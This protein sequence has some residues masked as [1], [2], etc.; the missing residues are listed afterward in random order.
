[1][2][3][4][5]KQFKDL[6][7]QAKMIQSKLAER[8]VDLDKGGIAMTMDGN[9]DITKLTISQEWLQPAKKESLEKALMELHSDIKKK[10]QK[11]MAEVMKETGGLKGMDLPF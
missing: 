5:L 3:N 1:M 10:A 7:G 8:S 6:R 2:F 9:N 11:K 4:K